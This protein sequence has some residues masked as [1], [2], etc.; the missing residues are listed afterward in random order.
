[1]IVKNRED[2]AELILNAC[3]RCGLSLRQLAKEAG[4]DRNTIYNIEN[5]RSGISVDILLK[6][7][8]ALKIEVA[9]ID[10]TDIL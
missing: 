7:R 5:C 8:D 9:I 3:K 4:V 10:T 1:M 6:L 2:I